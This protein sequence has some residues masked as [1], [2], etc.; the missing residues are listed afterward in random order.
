MEHDEVLEVTHWV[1]WGRPINLERVEERLDLTDPT[2]RI[3]LG[4]TLWA[5]QEPHRAKWLVH[6]TL[7]ERLTAYTVKEW[8]LMGWGE[9]IISCL[10]GNII[11]PSWSQAEEIARIWG[12]GTLRSRIA[13]TR[14]ATSAILS[15]KQKTYVG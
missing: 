10:Q 5:A 8:A 13:Q 9:A 14:R 7:S 1:L 6:E 2:D 4:W 12:Y 3:F 15:R 11:Q